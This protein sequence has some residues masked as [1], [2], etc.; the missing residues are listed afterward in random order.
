M[1]DNQMAEKDVKWWIMLS[2][3]GG[4]NQKLKWGL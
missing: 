1:V 3:G 2:T 4:G